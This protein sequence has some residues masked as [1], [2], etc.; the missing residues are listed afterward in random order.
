MQVY[1]SYSTRD[2][3]GSCQSTVFEGLEKFTLMKLRH[4]CNSY[5]LACA[6]LKVEWLREPPSQVTQHSTIIVTVNVTAA[7][8]YFT[9]DN[10][11]GV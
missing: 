8:S 1:C 10:F 2:V 6:G 7:P 4:P 3:W 5:Y 9:T 11:P